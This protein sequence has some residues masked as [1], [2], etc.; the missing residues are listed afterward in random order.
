MVSSRL[1][2]GVSQNVKSSVCVGWGPKVKFSQIITYTC[3]IWVI[4]SGI[5]VCVDVVNIKGATLLQKW[6]KLSGRKCYLK[7]LE[8]Q[9]VSL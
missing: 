2:Q 5:H 8:D 4:T 9:I 3:G 7:S 1:I 6:L